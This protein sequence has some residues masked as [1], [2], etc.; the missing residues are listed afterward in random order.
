MDVILVEREEEEE[1]EEVREEEGRAICDEETE[2]VTAVAVVVALLWRSSCGPACVCSS[3]ADVGC[4][5]QLARFEALVVVWNW[6]MALRSA[7]VLK[8]LRKVRVTAAAVVAVLLL[9]GEVV[10]VRGE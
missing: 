9:I 6:R 8:G 10:A 3:S 4:M 7:D 2:L 5:I 1:E